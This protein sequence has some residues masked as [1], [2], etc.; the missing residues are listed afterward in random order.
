[1]KYFF[2]WGTW[3]EVVTSDILIAFYISLSIY[4][5]YLRSENILENFLVIF[6]FFLLITQLG[7]VTNF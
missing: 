4:F 7:R 3:F 6:N 2:Q 1:M 5:I